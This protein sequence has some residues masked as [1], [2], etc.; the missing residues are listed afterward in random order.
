MFYYLLV[1]MDEMSKI[2]VVKENSKI[3][4][5]KN[6]DYKLKNFVMEKINGLTN[7]FYHRLSNQI[8]NCQCSTDRKSENVTPLLRG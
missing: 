1:T 3:G 5:G 4:N 7:G 8:I 2:V 6:G